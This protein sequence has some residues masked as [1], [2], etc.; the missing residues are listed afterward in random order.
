MGYCRSVTSFFRNQSASLVF[1]F[2]VATMFSSCTSQPES[3]TEEDQITVNTYTEA[4]K[5]G[6]FERQPD[7]LQKLAIGVIAISDKVDDKGI[8]LQAFNLC[9]ASFDM[10]GYPDSAI[11]YAQKMQA[12]ATKIDDQMN[13][14]RSHNIM[15]L[16]NIRKQSFEEAE[17][18]LQK[19]IQINTLAGETPDIANYYQ[20]LG[21]LNKET[22]HYDSAIYYYQVAAQKFELNDNK[23]ALAVTYGNI[24]SIHVHLKNYD[25]ALEY[26]N[27]G[28]AI[29]K[30][31]NNL[32]SLTHSYKNTGIVFARLDKP[33]IAKLYY[34][35]AIDI[36]KT[37]GNKP[38][39][40]A[41]T[42]NYANVL[43]DEGQFNKALES[44]FDI[45]A[46]AK[47]MNFNIWIFRSKLAIG[48]TYLKI[49]EYRKAND[50]LEEAIKL[51]D[52]KG[53]TEGRERA[54]LNITQAAIGLN[55]RDK[56]TE[57]LLIYTEAIDSLN[58]HNQQ[59][60]VSD[61]EARYQLNEKDTK[62]KYMDQVN[63]SRT[64][65]NYALIAAIV[66]AIFLFVFI[67]LLYRTNIK[68]LNLKN[69][70]IEKDNVLKQLKL[71]KAG[72]QAK[73]KEEEA[74]K[75]ALSLEIK[76]ELSNMIAHDLKN[77]LNNII[78]SSDDNPVIQNKKLR[79]SGKKMLNMVSNILD[80]YKYEF[81]KMPI[82]TSENNL[83]KIAEKAIGEVEYSATQKNI[84]LRNL[85]PSTIRVN[86]DPDLLIRVFVNLLTNAIK[87]SPMNGFV[88]LKVDCEKSDSD[89]IRVT[90]SDTGY[91]IPT[92]MQKKVF[93]KFSQVNANNSHAQGSTGL[94]LTFCKMAIEAHGG[95]IG[96]DENYT[97]GTQ[98]FFTLPLISKIEEDIKIVAPLESPIELTANE[99]ADLSQYLPR[100]VK[101]EIYDVSELRIIVK[102]IELEPNINKEWLADL[103]NAVNFGNEQKLEFLINQI[104]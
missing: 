94:G 40:I 41:V 32:N 58:F 50:Y 89:F 22:G 99:K 59:K 100:L 67:L 73:L 60:I 20:S 63:Q 71:E 75:L 57:T 26:Y 54:L 85:F 7:S 51:A 64:R 28:I 80:V 14:A 55:D 48:K 70:R 43:V 52:E 98:I 56:A 76:E 82:S 21:V 47:E 92:E 5:D 74:E 23:R 36:T 27:K 11:F 1:F 2:L 46:M 72:M 61:L 8:V 9:A 79:Q 31:I 38:M 33:E 78:N 90:I 91:G 35:S 68:N 96:I 16:A 17:A 3:L 6:L 87:Y 39:M 30:Q 101:L 45:L 102:E 95:K 97:D 29:N 83:L 65:L 81:T 86:T 37:T 103:N 10:G 24:G 104:K 77:P 19:A 62:L 84:A 13:L 15:A 49:G 42:F 18:H 66:L 44:Y 34:D 69:D 12:Y 4:V 88:E 25:E 53:I 93:E